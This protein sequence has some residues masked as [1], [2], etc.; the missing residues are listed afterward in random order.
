MLVTIRLAG[1]IAVVVVAAR[2]S[3]VAVVVMFVFVTR[4]AERSVL[5]GARTVVAM[6][7]APYKGVQ[8]Q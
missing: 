3:I 8:Q 7:A 6:R 5:T 4:G 2:S 1:R